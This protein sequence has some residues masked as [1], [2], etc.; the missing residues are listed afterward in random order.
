MNLLDLP[1]FRQARA[2]LEALEPKPDNKAKENK[3][4]S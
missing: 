2:A 1:E 3:K 4:E